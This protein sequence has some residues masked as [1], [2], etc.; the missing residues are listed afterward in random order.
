MNHC[1]IQALVGL[2]AIVLWPNAC[3]LGEDAPHIVK[4]LFADDPDWDGFRNRLLPARRHTVRQDFGYRTTSHAG[5]KRAGEIGGF[6]QRSPTA[7]TYARRIDRKTLD[8]RLSASGRLA[9]RGAEGASGVM[10]GWFR[11]VPTG[12]RT[13][14]SLAMR[15]DGNGGK[16]WVFYEYGTS[17]HRTGRRRQPLKASNTRPRGRVRLPPT[18]R[19]TIGR[20]TTIPPRAT[21]KG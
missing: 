7:A 5:G 2:L 20:S 13:P 1:R 19:C 21:D 12:W 10:I 14:N 18:E 11:D 4:Q 16:Y 6:V 3:S 9:V 15:I 8:D 17:D